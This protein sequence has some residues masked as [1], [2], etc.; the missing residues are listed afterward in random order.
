MTTRRQFDAVSHATFRDILEASSERR[1]HSCRATLPS[2][3]Q[4]MAM[5]QGRPF[6]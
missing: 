1:L 2:S 3:M 5:M 4:M 6:Q